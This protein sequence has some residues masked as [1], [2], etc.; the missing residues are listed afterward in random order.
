M[1]QSFL[2]HIG[3][4]GRANLEWTVTHRRSFDEILA[5]LPKVAPERAF[6][7]NDPQLH[8]A[9]PDKRFHCWGVPW[10]AK[11]PFTRARI[12]DLVIIV[13]SC[14]EGVR[15]IGIVRAKCTV[16]CLDASRILWPRSGRV[17]PYLL[18]F[19]AESV[20][21]TWQDF[22]QDVGYPDF[23]S[24]RG[25]FRRISPKRLAAFGGTAGYLQFLRNT[26][27]ET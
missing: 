8:E 7:E 21:R 12:G 13:P 4:P 18:F 16:P 27:R 24:L 11:G 20:F 17:F 14:Q 3:D 1:R 22:L 6:F 15:H 26:R 19:D 9:F 25:N 10:K 2:N 5:A 23:W